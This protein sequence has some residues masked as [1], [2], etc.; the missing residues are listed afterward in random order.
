MRRLHIIGRGSALPL[1]LAA[2]VLAACSG[3][4]DR[5]ADTRASRSSDTSTTSA[6]TRAARR[7]ELADAH[8]SAAGP[9]AS[10]STAAPAQPTPAN[11][12]KRPDELHFVCPEGG[13]DEV[14]ALQ[15]AVDQGHQPWRLSAQDVAA[16]CTFGIPDT[17][18][19]PA[20]MNRYRVAHTRTGESAI[21]EVAQ[22]LGPNGIWVV[23]RVTSS[24]RPTT[25]GA[26]LCTAEAILPVVRQELERD[27]VVHTM[28][29]AVIVQQC[30]NGYARVSTVPDNST[31]G[32]PGGSCIENE[33]V[34]LTATAAG[35]S[36][37]TSGT[38]ISCATDYD[39]FPAL[40]TACEELGLR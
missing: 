32:Q 34:F 21:V 35:W 16:A 8:R 12:T 27:A 18:V 37:L 1:L 39:L 3:A 7:A 6:V 36:Y 10:T 19:E 5:A 31:C 17:T 22:P 20:G 24:P 25:A 40:L 15:H 9:P 29:A 26:A 28:V 14:V 30:Q 38:G 23:T 13:I 2:T 4:G 33:Q 11:K